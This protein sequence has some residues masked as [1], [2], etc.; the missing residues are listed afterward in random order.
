[1]SIKKCKK[2]DANKNNG[3][4]RFTGEKIKKTDWSYI[5]DV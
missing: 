3:V 1:M 5:K 4:E 2:Q